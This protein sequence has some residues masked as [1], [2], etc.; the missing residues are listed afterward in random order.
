MN[1]LPTQKN[2]TKNIISF[3]GCLKGKT[4][5]PPSSLFPISIPGDALI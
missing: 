3:Y 4:R 2:L 5:P 1:A